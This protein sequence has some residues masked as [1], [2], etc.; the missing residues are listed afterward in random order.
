ML[1]LKLDR[2][3]SP[4]F[5]TANAKFRIVVFALPGEH[6]VVIEIRRFIFQVPLTDHGRVIPGLPHLNGEHL[7]AWWNAARKIHG[8]VGVTV[9]SRQ[10]A[11]PR[12]RAYRV[13]AEGVCEQSAFSRESIDIWCWSNGRKTAA[14]R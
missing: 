1:T 7:L 5:V 6:A 12:R 14:I 8:R 13:G 9:L 3:F 10:N 2:I 4:R 11:S